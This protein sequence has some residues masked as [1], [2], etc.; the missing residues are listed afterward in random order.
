MDN[1]FPEIWIPYLLKFR[2]GFSKPTFTYF[3]GFI[4]SLL[5]GQS[6]KCL[7]HI[8]D[9][10]IFV[11]KS[12]S[13]WHR[14]LSTFQW[15]LSEV[16]ESMIDLLLSELGDSLSYAGHLLLAV[17]PTMVKKVK[18]KMSGVQKWRQNSTHPDK[19]VIGHQ[20]VI[21]G[22]LARVKHQ[23]HCLPVIS[24]L[25]SG[26]S[27]PSHFVVDTQGNAQPMGIIAAVLAAV[28]FVK[29][30]VKAK[31]LCVVAD[32]FFSKA[33]FINPL[34]EQGI[35][36]VTRL[37]HD[38]V[39]FLPPFYCG[40]G[41]PPKRG[42]CIKLAKC[43]NQ[44]Q[45]QTTTACLY[46]KQ[47]QVQYLVIDLF[48]RDVKRKVRVVIADGTNRPILLVSTSLDLSPTQILEIYAARFSIEIA[49][50][51]LKQHFGLG[52]YQSTTTLAFLRFT[53]LCCIAA[54]L[55]RLVL[56]KHHSPEGIHET[57]SESTT[58][59]TVS[60][61]RQQLRRFVMRQLIFNK[62]TDG[63]DFTKCHIDIKAIFRIAA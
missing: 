60:S 46:G 33:N 2:Q 20:W 59:S 27:N 16:I 40:R 35:T 42:K 43:F 15:D 55:A 38:A 10:C 58:T 63:A 29:N 53:Q 62:S 14:F 31:P 32:A 18:G 48:L 1:F 52:D 45:R 34:V 41:R 54:S 26:K 57:A 51:E 25:I 7:T 9:T 24:R 8:A 17:D 22:F 6:R 36:L 21:A 12:L 56:L 39:G 11:D 4:F 28:F 3:V 49:I 19:Q 44:M 50:R 23:W 30:S 47:C 13:G 5:I 61:V 37:R